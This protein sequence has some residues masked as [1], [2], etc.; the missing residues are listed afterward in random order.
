MGKDVPSAFY[1]QKR[2]LRSECVRG[3]V[4]EAYTSDPHI[5]CTASPTANNETFIP[6]I[7][8]ERNGEE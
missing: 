3:T 2:K 1:C 4:T 7:M 6:Q 8:K 5:V